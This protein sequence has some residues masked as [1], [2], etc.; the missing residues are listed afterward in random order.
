[1]GYI[2]THGVATVMA[3]V[4][5]RRAPKTGSLY[6]RKSDGMWIGTLENGENEKGKRRR[7]TVSAKTKALCQRKLR[8]KQ[9]EIDRGEVPTN[10][11]ATVKSWADEW[12]T[13]KADEL[14][15][16]SY[17]SVRT[18][19]RMWIVPTI[20]HKR[21]ASLSPADARAVETAVR[22]KRSP[23]T[24]AGVHRTL[25]NMLRAA[26]REGHQV[27]QSIQI[28]KA[29]AVPK[30]DRDALTI[31]ETLACLAVASQL[32]HGS[33]WVFAL[34]YGMRQ[35]EC[36]GLT[37]DAID[38]DRGT[39]TVEWQLQRIPYKDLSDKAAGFRVPDHIEVRHLHKT[40][41]LTRPK[42][43]AGFRVIPLL[44]GVVTALERWREVAPANPWG[45]VWPNR[46]GT[47]CLQ[48]D[49]L[50]EW[51]AIQGSA[52]VGH[53][54]GRPYHVHECRNVAATHLVGEDANVVKSLLGHSDIVV[55][56]G[57]QRV[58]LAPKRE[59]LERVAGILGI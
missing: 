21:L 5:S 44:P 10:V 41:H 11:R 14:R 25:V 12:L 9:A 24:A 28:A 42:S 54:A 16:K 4:T 45:L 20:G 48:L 38:F 56:H 7:I 23:G 39:V 47:P 3:T 36:L 15:P 22:A 59:A 58:D 13:L 27:P 29:P 26:V 51:H 52:C 49:D 40:W 19:V 6:Q 33:R 18:H 50:E 53:P 43:R 1:M 46:R 35:G 17:N 55:S 8:D 32:D 31:P 30:S 57:Y 37:W 2:R 34:L